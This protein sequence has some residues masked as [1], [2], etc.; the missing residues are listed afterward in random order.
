MDKDICLAFMRVSSELRQPKHGFFQHRCVKLVIDKVFLLVFPNEI[1]LFQL[2][3]VIRD[4]GSRHIKF[5]GNLSRRHLSMSQQDQDFPADRIGKR[6]KCFLKSQNN[7]PF[8]EM[9]FRCFSK[10]IV[11][12][13][14]LFVKW[15]LEIFQNSFK[16]NLLC[17]CC[18]RKGWHYFTNSKQSGNE[19]KIILCTGL[20]FSLSLR[21]LLSKI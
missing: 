4:G 21:N 15:Y 5:S 12:A 9:V 18:Q 8:D 17:T 13:Q 6:F 20:Q 1:C 3:K 11:A 7:P 2:G 14:E 10:Q 19:N 16:R